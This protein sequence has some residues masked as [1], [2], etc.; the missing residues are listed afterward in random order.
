MEQT[1]DINF[2]LHFPET[3]ESWQ[4]LHNLEYDKMNSN[5]IHS[6]ILESSTHNSAIKS[7]R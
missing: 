5:N 7:G 2:R 1:A 3:Y 6:N 4:F